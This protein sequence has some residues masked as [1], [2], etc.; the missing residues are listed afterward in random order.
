MVIDAAFIA[1][2]AASLAG[3]VLSVLIERLMMPRPPLARPWAAWA[4]HAGMCL[5]AHAVLTLMVG[6]PWFAA[7]VVS[8]FL[9]VL[10]LVNNAKVKALRFGI[11]VSTSRF[12]AG[13]SFLARQRVW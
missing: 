5:S 12:W 7:A 3:L 9:L 10:V 4:L 11:R 8:A 13:G 1:V 2:L 6:R